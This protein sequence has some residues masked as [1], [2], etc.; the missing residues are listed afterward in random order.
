MTVRTSTCVHKAITLFS[1]TLTTTSLTYYTSLFSFVLFYFVRATYINYFFTL[2]HLNHFTKNYTQNCETRFLS[3]AVCLP[4]EQKTQKFFFFI[5]KLVV[6]PNHSNYRLQRR[7]HESDGNPFPVVVST[8]RNMWTQKCV[9]VNVLVTYFQVRPRKL[10]F[11]TWNL[12][13]LNIV[14]C[15]SSKLGTLCY[16]IFFL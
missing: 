11:L 2:N 5:G 7:F 10:W 12:P 4:R 6:L 1:K 15:Y 9:R 3:F 16:Q 13:S 8:Q 14:E